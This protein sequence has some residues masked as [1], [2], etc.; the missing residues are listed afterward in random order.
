MLKTCPECRQLF[1]VDKRTTEM[2]KE[3]FIRNPKLKIICSDCGN[4]LEYKYFI[5]RKNK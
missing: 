3:S 2:L 1:T 5:I 4:K